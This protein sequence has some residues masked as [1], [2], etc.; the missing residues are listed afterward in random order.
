MKK[1]LFLLSFS[2]FLVIL[3][4]NNVLAV[5][6]NLIAR[7]NM[8]T[9]SNN[10]MSDS[11]GN[12]LNGITSGITLVNGKF[13]NAFNFTG[14]GFA[15]V[16]D[17]P[18]LEP[19]NLSIEAWVKS[20]SSPGIYKYIISKGVNGCVNASYALYTGIN[21]G[22]QFYVAQ[23]NSYILSPDA[24]T[25]VWDGNWHHVTGTFD[26]SNIRLYVDQTE[27]G[28]GTSANSVINYNLP[29]GNNLTVGNYIN[30]NCSANYGFTGQIDEVRLWNRALSAAEISQH[31]QTNSSAVFPYT[32]I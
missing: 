22:L 9:L 7:W 8:N 19:A 4:N 1:F 6:D 23:G 21:G 20:A 3:F 11:S 30:P 12:N 18:L 29:D 14:N 5:E 27:I 17:N 2:L 16:S 13:G 31:A 15:T 10:M 32:G 24:G 26:G 25:G 28:N